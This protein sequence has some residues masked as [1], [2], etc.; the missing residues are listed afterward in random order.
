MLTQTQ[1]HLIPTFSAN[2]INANDFGFANKFNF[3]RIQYIDL[4]FQSTILMIHILTKIMAFVPY[5]WLLFRLNSFTG[6][7]KFGVNI[8]K[9]LQ[10]K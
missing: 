5:F 10:F 4:Q 2:F 1:S 7:R 9:K 3:I 8:A 6:W